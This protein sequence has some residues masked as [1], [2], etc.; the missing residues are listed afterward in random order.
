[1]TTATTTS[2]PLTRPTTGPAT[3]APTIDI[4]KILVQNLWWF[5][6]ALVVGVGLGIGVFILLRMYAPRYQSETILQAAN[7]RD[8][9]GDITATGDDKELDR[10]INSQ[11]AV[12]KSEGVVAA[13]AGDP[14]TRAQ[15]PEWAKKF[16]KGGSFDLQAATEDLSNRIYASAI[17]NTSLIKLGARH[18]TAREAFALATRVREQYLV[19]LTDQSGRGTLGLRTEYERQIREASDRI[20]QLQ[21]DRSSR[22]LAANVD[23]LDE[24]SASIVQ[25]ITEINK[26]MAEVRNLL[27]QTQ[28]TLDKYRQQLEL[29]PGSIVYPD[30]VVDLVE[31]DPSVRT[32]RQ[33]ISDIE[34]QIGAMRQEGYGPEHR[35]ITSLQAQR[36]SWVQELEQERQKLLRQKFD[37][38]VDSLDTAVS[39]YRAQ[40]ADLMRRLE[41]AASER[42][43]LSRLIGEIDNLDLELEEA[44][45]RRS[46]AE[47]E[48]ENLRSLMSLPDAGRISLVQQ[49]RLPEQLSF[50]KPIIII[51][52]VALL[53]VASVFGV[54]FLREM[55][56]QRIKT[57]SDVAMARTR[58]LAVIPDGA[59]TPEGTTDALRIFKDKPNSVLS[60]SF[61][62]AK[63]PLV[64]KLRRS[65]QKTLTVVSGMPES[66]ATTFATNLALSCAASEMRVLLIDAN[67]RRP[68]LHGILGG[69]EAPGLADALAGTPVSQAVQSIDDGH[70]DLLSAGTASL[71]V[72]ER[73]ST[74]AMSRI[75]D[76]AREHYDLVIVDTPPVVVSGDAKALANRTD[77]TLLVVRAF[78]ETRG[79]VARVRQELE[80]ARAEFLG[81]VINRVRPSAGGYMRTNLRA[82]AD[83][84][85]AKG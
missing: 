25:Q 16:E 22:L 61:R 8:T 56:D 4:V 14:R 51:P 53:C 27:T 52:G 84:Q 6:G 10:F 30:A 75:L 71:R 13:I 57:P 44:I 67:L 81:V 2:A 15:A 18:S 1:M 11:V 65:G 49:E 60:E 3:G 37:A 46:E 54:V 62:Q 45:R 7:P 34:A 48:L 82:T 59:Q 17:P 31:S 38:Q 12:M 66:G 5:V 36:E 72:V 28:T 63:A 64:E 77:A 47:A 26:S 9:L 42:G 23:S 55:L 85:S 29:S 21:Q 70:L 74:D 76:E 39:Q 32:I 68:R 73:L 79:L 19:T 43:V 20:R 83:Y 50:P 58:V 33:R 41:G 40:E 78:S 35:A 69:R 80:Q 24:K